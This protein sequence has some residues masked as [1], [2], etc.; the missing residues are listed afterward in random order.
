MGKK[1]I[2]ISDFDWTGSGYATLSIPLLKGLAGLGH[3]IK[4]IGIGYQGQEHDYPFSIIPTQNV[5]DGVALAGNL[6]VLWKPDLFIVALDIP[7]QNFFQSNLKPYNRKYIGITPLENG[8]L[9]MSW[10]VILMGM[11]GVFLISELGKQ[12]AIKAGVV[13]AEHLQIGI[14]LQQ[15]RTPTSDERSTLR[16]GLGIAENEFVVLTVADNQERKNLSAGIEAIAKTKELINR[17]IKYIL[18]TRKD[19]PFGWKFPD[20]PAY[21]GVH[22]EVQVFERGLPLKDLWGLYAVADVYLQPSKAEGLGLPVMDAMACGVPVVATDTGALHELLQDR[23]GYL[24]PSAFS[25]IDVWGNSRRDMVDVQLCAATLRGIA[26]NVYP[27]AEVKNALDYIHTR[28][29]D[30]AVN[31]VDKK[32]EELFDEQTK[33]TQ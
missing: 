27:D 4:A 11:D 19:S 18:V 5:Q 17:P 7:L 12:E 22:K 33:P 1:I 32:I 9:T 31:Q 6:N 13:K 28:T 29:W 24:V 15:W 20:L 25:F 10:S 2:Y 16:K 8:P 14:D 21:F 23:R 26:D 30:I 3:E